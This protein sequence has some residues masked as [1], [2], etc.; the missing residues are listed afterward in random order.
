MTRK[1][2]FKAESKRLLDL[3]INS[4][5]T[6][7]DIFL[8]EIIS[9]ASDA[10]DKLHFKSLQDGTIELNRDDYKI[11][12]SIDRSKRQL[13]IKDN[14]IGMNDKELQDYLGTIAKSDS[15][16]F[17]NGNEDSEIIGQFGVGFYSAFMVSESIRVESKHFGEEASY[18]F[19]ST[20]LDGYTIEPVEKETHGTTIYCTLKENTETYNYDQYLDY[21]TIRDLVKTYSDY[22]QYPI[23]L[24]EPALFEDEEKGIKE[25]D[26]LENTLNSRVPLWKRSK[27]DIKTEDLNQFYKEKFYGYD[28][29]LK[30]IHMRV[31][32]VPSF[33]A[34]LYI[35]SVTPM[36]FYSNQYESGL[37]LYSRGVYI[38]EHN[39]DLLPDHFR[40]VR[41]LVDSPDLSLN[42]SREILQ[43]DHQI[44]VIA[45]RIEKKIQSEL[46]LMLKNDREN[47][48]SFWNNFGST[49]K[50]G[51]YDHFGMH[52][53]KLQD[54]LMF[55]TSLGKL[56]T[57]NEYI[58]RMKVDQE[59]IYYVVGDSVEKCENLPITEYVL[60]KGYEVLYLSDPIDEFVVQILNQYDGKSFQSITQGDL[61][62]M[63]DDQKES[64]ESKTEDHKDLIEALEKSLEG[65]V[66]RVK[67]STRL[68]SHPVSLVSDAGISIEMEQVL[69]QLS[70]AQDVPKAS[71]IL[72]INLDHD[73]LK[74]LKNVYENQP[75]GLKG[76]AQL[77]YDQACLIEGLALEDPVAFSQNMAR[78]M[79]EVSKV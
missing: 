56:S 28:D 41:G 65:K 21:N 74:A 6:N 50:Y 57:L 52:K 19:S 66:T 67:L 55:T 25:G 2:Q 37:Q 51:V 29:P 36:N 48:E 75:D 34:L 8:R 64:L 45:K 68:G 12:L 10:I 11:E 69:S 46:E 38:M 79:V 3:M 22:I 26:I 54:L 76:Y 42:I 33:D 78:L 17:K 44:K 61:D 14:G 5:Y 70:D 15:F 53:E 63:D 27:S 40:F 13:I 62:L 23:I 59:T 9:N 31:E 18:A 43:N 7:K 77:L 72:E 73:V 60:S 58:A 39:K 49:L 24:K 35:P 32:G 16:D 30:T 71:R 20:G 47:Y 1:K 4:I